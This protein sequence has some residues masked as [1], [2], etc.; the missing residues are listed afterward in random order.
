[1]T[2]PVLSIASKRWAD[3]ADEL[4]FQQLDTARRQAE[5]WRPW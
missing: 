1:V 2:P 3:L 4:E 5:G